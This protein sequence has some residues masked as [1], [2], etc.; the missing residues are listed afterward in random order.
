MLLAYSRGSRKVARE[1]ARDPEK[2]SS[3]IS[4]LK[5]RI[6][7][8]SSVGTQESRL[9]TWDLIASDAGL[10]P[11]LFSSELVYTVIAVL[12]AAEYRSAEL[13][14]ADAKARYIQ[15]GGHIS[16]RTHQACKRASRATRRGR[17]PAKQ[18]QHL[19]LERFRELPSTW[20]PW[21]AN[22]PV[23]PKRALSVSSRWLLREL[24]LA[25]LKVGHCCDKSPSAADLIM[26]IFLPVSKAD[27]TAL[28][29]FRRLGCSCNE[30]C[31][32]ID[33]CPYHAVSAQI[34]WLKEQHFALSPEDFADLSLFPTC[35]GDI[36]AKSAVVQTIRH[37]ASLLGERLQLESGAERYGGHTPRATGAVFY[38]Q[39]G[40][41]TWRIQSL[42][43]WGSDAI[44]GYL[45]GSHIS[46]LASI[47]Q[48]A[49]LAKSIES[50]R[51]ELGSL[52]E[53]ARI[54]R[55]RLAAAIQDEAVIPDTSSNTLLALTSS[56]LLDGSAMPSTEEQT[57]EN[58]QD[59]P[60]VRNT[61]IDGLL[62]KITL[63]SLDIPSQNWRSRCGW[64][65]GR[66]M[67]FSE[68]TADPMA[69]QQCP[70]CFA[71]PHA[72][73]KRDR[74]PSSSASSATP[75]ASPGTRST[76]SSS[77]SSSS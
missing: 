9:E 11:A 24:E 43:R 75:L 59:L 65:F 27:I 12:S 35:N 62:H 21:S 71:L 28:G 8:N 52:Q 14:L 37:A 76:S 25:H 51:A 73:W 29:A 57:S 36:P 77:S 6:F 19:D 46:G 18:S 39:A 67:R 31:T 13:Y 42:G 70:N 2:L 4:T 61:K 68:R 58:L 20:N 40:V 44:K 74:R 50:S 45:R 38:A 63:C 23:W 41:D 60:Y 47:S 33:I 53:Q 17:G 3:S 1:I 54:I 16:P 34:A 10:N 49:S 30:N 48:E 64:R 26:E 72:G 22:G 5:G 15:G 69:A 66:D 56:D 55:N 32:D 7:S